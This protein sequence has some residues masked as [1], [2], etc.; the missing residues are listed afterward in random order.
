MLPF[1]KRPVNNRKKNLSTGSCK[2]KNQIVGEEKNCLRLQGRRNRSGRGG[3]IA[4]PDFVRS[5]NPIPTRKSRLCP[6]YYYSTSYIF[7]PSYG[8]GL[9]KKGKKGSQAQLVHTPYVNVTKHEGMCVI[10]Q[11]C[12]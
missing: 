7:K 11:S 4:Q 3:D 8:P 2:E 6:P 9:V 1:F 12:K 5:V 10:S